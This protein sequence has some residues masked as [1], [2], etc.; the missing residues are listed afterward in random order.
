[1]LGQVLDV[2]RHEFESA[3]SPQGF[4][5]FHA[6]GMDRMEFTEAQDRLNYLIM[7]FIDKNR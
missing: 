4:L 2:V 3:N 7:E 6:Q 5:I 1:M